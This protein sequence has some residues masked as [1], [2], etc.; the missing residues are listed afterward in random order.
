MTTPVDP[1]LTIAVLHRTAGSVRAI[2]AS[3]GEGPPTVRAWQT[4]DADDQTAIDAWLG[5]GA[6]MS[7]A[8]RNLVKKQ[9]KQQVALASGGAA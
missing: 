7:D 3:T 5:K 9:K 2:V 6:Q 8:V 1:Q 4:F